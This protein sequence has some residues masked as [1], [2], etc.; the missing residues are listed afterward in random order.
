MIDLGGS[1][2]SLPFVAPKPFA[3]GCPRLAVIDPPAPVMLVKRDL[4]DALSTS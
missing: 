4:A 1:L 2:F 3:D